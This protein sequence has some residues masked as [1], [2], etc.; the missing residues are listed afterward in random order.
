M[1]AILSTS[2]L[3]DY[4]INNARSQRVEI[5]AIPFIHVSVIADDNVQQEIALLKQANI[6][7]VFTSANAVKAIAAAQGKKPDWMIYCIGNATKNE[8][9]TVV[10]DTAIKG[11]ASNAAALAETMIQDRVQEVIFF[12]GDKRLDI[13]PA[14]LRENGCTVREVIVYKTEETPVAVTKVYDGI[15]FFSPSAVSGFFSINKVG[16]EVV[17]FAIGDTTAKA[18]K[19][20]AN[21]KVIVC[22]NVSKEQVVSEA[23]QFFS[24][25]G[26]A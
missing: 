8:L 23:I 18:I 14:L 4:I 12:C 9:L 3:D 21:N 2:L 19:E 10:N 25:T 11:A 20:R 5:D 13:L 24:I 1:A 7:A 26:K 22:G 6:T 16:P 15:L 17:L